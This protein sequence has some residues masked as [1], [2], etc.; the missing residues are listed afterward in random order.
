MTEKETR[1]FLDRLFS[2]FDAL[3]SV[4]GLFKA[5]DRECLAHSTQQRIAFLP[6]LPDRTRPADAHRSEFST[7]SFLA[8]DPEQIGG[9]LHGDMWHA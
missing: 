1:G 7:F 6:S 5:R 4:F 9:H 3:A 8:A 2:S